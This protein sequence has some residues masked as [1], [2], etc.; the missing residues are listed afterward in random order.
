MANLAETV[1]W[2]P[3]IY[4]LETTDL[5]LGGDPSQGGVSN[6]QAQQLGDR[7][8]YLYSLLG[9]AIVNPVSVTSF[10]ALTVQDVVN[11]YVVLSFNQSGYDVTLPAGLNDGTFVRI[12]CD[13]IPG[14]PK[15]CVKLRPPAGSSFL[16]RGQSHGYMYLYGGE[17]VELIKSGPYFIIHHSQSNFFEV[18]EVLHSYTLPAAQL[19]IQSSGQLLSRIQYGRLWDWVNFNGAVVSESNYLLNPTLYSGCFT[20]GNGSTTFRIPDLRGVFMRGL[21]N[22]RGIDVNRP[23]GTL[24]GVYQ[25]D[26]LKS[27]A[28]LVEFLPAPGKGTG[29]GTQVVPLPQGTTGGTITEQAG[30]I[31]TRPVNIA[32]TAYI[33][34]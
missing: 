34:Y 20:T 14:N 17:T 5:V 10:L 30:G 25:S 27:H 1:Q 22:G 9:K 3:G 32:Y 31:E 11:K 7:T 12:S 26:E 15:H 33:K 2:V 24:N 29:A 23:A 21:D 18:G 19:A 6:I 16:G 28:H 4:Q 8:A 13:Y